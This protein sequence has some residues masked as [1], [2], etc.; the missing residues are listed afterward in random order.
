VEVIGDNGDV[1]IFSQRTEEVVGGVPHVVDEVVAVGGELKQHNG[2][3]GGLSDADAGDGLGDAVLEDQEVIGLE[4]G[5]ELVGLVED[6]VGV[7][8]DDG[9]VDPERVGVAVRVLDL[10]LGRRGGGR[11]G[12]V[13]ILLFLEDDGAVVGR[14]AGVVGGRSGGLGL[15]LGRRGRGILGL[16]AGQREEEGEGAGG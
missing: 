8:V 6:D 3:D 14:G 15:L 13:R 7:D 16:G 4:A 9:D 2:G 12:L 10:W 11:R 1:V 5:D